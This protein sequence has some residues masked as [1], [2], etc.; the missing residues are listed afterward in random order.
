MDLSRPFMTPKNHMQYEVTINDYV[1]CNC[2]DF[3]SMMVGS[4]DK[5]GP[6]VPCK[7]LYYI[8]QYGMYYK[9]R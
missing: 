7:H 9:I 4:L 5:W 2:M 3:S 8:L 1:A 6:W